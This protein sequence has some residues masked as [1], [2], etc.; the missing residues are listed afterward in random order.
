[1][2]SS[3]INPALL[4]DKDALLPDKAGLFLRKRHEK[5]AEMMML[6]FF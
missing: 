2:F 1:M 5:C 6:L 4:R 3:S